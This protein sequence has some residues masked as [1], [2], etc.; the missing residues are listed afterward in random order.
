MNNTK[1]GKRKIKKGAKVVLLLLAVWLILGTIVAFKVTTPSVN[2]WILKD[3]HV[4]AQQNGN[5]SNWE[6]KDK[7]FNEYNEYS[8]SLVNSEDAMI[9]WF[10]QQNTL[11]K[12]VVYIV[13]IAP[14]ALIAFAIVEEISEFF[15]K[16]SDK[17]T[18]LKK[19]RA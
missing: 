13:S 19:C 10:F 7:A 17:D 16:K 12:L 11:V 3:N 5:P 6:A 2:S 4:Y 9:G 1:K 8:N 18:Q 14:L 15:T